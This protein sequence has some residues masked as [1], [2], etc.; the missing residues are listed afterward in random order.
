MSSVFLKKFNKV[1]HLKERKEKN[2][3]NCNAEVIGRYCHIC[4]QENVEIKESFWQLATHLIYDIM[5]FDSKFFET[6]KYLLFRPG[7][8][9]KEYLR[10]RRA[11]YLHPIKMYV[12]TSAIFFIIFF[13]FV[14][15]PDQFNVSNKAETEEGKKTISEQI[16]LLQDSLK[17]TRDPKQREKIEDDIHALNVVASYIPN[18]DMEEKK[19]STDST[20]KKNDNVFNFRDS[21][22]SGEKEYDSLQN[23][24][25]ADARDGWLTRLIMYRAITINEKYK[26][27]K[28]RFEE[29]FVE[30]F[31]HSIPQMMFILLP[32]LAFILQ[33][34]YIRRRKEFYYVDHVI[35]LVHTYIAIFI[36]LL[37]Y[38]GFDALK[39][40]TGWSLF[41]WLKTIVGIY[42]F[43]YCLLAMYKFYGQ[44]IIKTIFK[45]F[46]L[47]FVGTILTSLL[48]VIFV[49]TSLFQI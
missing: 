26:G 13:A 20:K 37:V 11:S 24:L 31:K 48:L 35:V 49:I 27:D 45:Y 47:L 2:C 40:V 33:L 43:L 14:I 10:G 1:S 25:S 5:H 46:I 41:S 36:S 38:Y 28:K 34:L 3:L 39:E 16:Q 9:S 18:V 7:F 12:F 19:D 21:M 29:D 32:L 30:K 17:K 44:G 42:I 15:K 23:K 22:P 8:L 4:G 6:L